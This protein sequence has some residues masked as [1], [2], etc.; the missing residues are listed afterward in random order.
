MDAV[1]A[2][3]RQLGLVPAVTRPAPWAFAQEWGGRGWITDIGGGPVHWVEFGGGDDTPIVFVH[4]LG[5]SHLNW[6]HVAPALATGRRAYALDMRGFGLTPG[7][8]R[9]TSIPA[10]VRLLGG[11]L[12]EVVCEPVV[13]VGNSMGG[14]IS[15]TRTADQSGTV[16]GLVLVDPALPPVSR[17]P[18][19]TVAGLF[20][21]YMLPGIGEFAMRMMQSRSTPEEAVQRVINLC[22]ADP[23]RIDP[24]MLAAAVELA[25]ARA[26]IRGKEESFL[27]ATRSLMWTLARAEG[28]RAVQRRIDVPVLLISGEA[29]R[30]VPVAAA[31]QAAAANPRWDSVFLPGV[32]H[33]PQLETPELVIDA[34]TGWLARTHSS[35]GR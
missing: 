23:G 30:L 17:R 16:T 35:T 13:L 19:L 1:P 27:R 4:G 15:A 26:P 14:L 12:K 20:A 2:A 6:V 10:N 21:T 29:D 34:V 28:H 5:G 22:F 8:P 3:G 25:K 11:F 7:W 32:G 33:T 24:R 18:D 9:D 31:R